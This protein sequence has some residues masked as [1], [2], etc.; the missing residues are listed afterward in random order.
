MRLVRYFFEHYTQPVVFLLFGEVAQQVV[1]ASGVAAEDEIEG[2]P[3]IVSLPH[4]AA[5]DNFLRCPNPF[6]TCNEKLLD[7]GARPVQW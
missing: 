1:V 2:H 7:A 6:I 4:P 5:G 3:A